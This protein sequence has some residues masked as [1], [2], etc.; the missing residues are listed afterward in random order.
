M[1]K[2]TR[3]CAISA[4]ML[5]AVSTASAAAQSTADRIMYSDEDIAALAEAEAA[6][7]EGNSGNF[8][9]AFVRSRVVQQRYL[10][11]NI[12]VGPVGK[13]QPI[14]NEDY[15]QFP[16]TMV[17][18]RWVAVDNE[19]DDVDVDKDQLQSIEPFFVTNAQTEAEVIEWQ[20]L[21]ATASG[22]DSNTRLIGKPGRLVFQRTKT[23][24]Q[25]TDDLTLE[26]LTKY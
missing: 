18:G 19:A 24:W 14:S 9:L 7:A 25:L 6:C 11:E 13:S 16:I 10:A 4:L 17:N 8:I 1:R 23:C 3:I 2:H 20:R 12:N 21:E 5:S 26:E 22:G 15:D